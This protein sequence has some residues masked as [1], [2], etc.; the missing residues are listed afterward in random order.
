ML[1]E[2]NPLSI[3]EN[4]YSLLIA[5]LDQFTRK[6]YINEILRGAIY[7]TALFLSTLLLASVLEYF[8][9]FGTTIR[10]FGFYSFLLLNVAGLLFWVLLPVSRL[11]RIGKVI[12]HKQAAHMIGE[13]FSD[14]KDKLLNTLELQESS[15]GSKDLI[16]ASIEQKMAELKPIPF[17]LAINF[18]GNKKY[19]KYALIPLLVVL[20][21]LIQVPDVILQ[22]SARIISYNEEFLPV[23]PFSFLL[24]NENLQILNHDD[25]EIK[26]KMEGRELPATV[27]VNIDGN[28]YRMVRN[29]PNEFS[30]LIRNVDKSKSFN[31]QA[32]GFSSE[33]YDLEVLPRPF[34]KSFQVAL[35]YPKYIGK[36]DEVL[37]NIGDFT[38]PEGTLVK[39]KFAAENAEDLLFNWN[40]V[41]EKGERIDRN[42]FRYSKQV[43]SAG[44]YY[45]QSI[46]EHVPVNDSIGYGVQ[47]IK[48]AHPTI[49]VTMEADTTSLKS[50]FFSGE[51]SDDYGLSALNFS[52][53]Y[54]QSE[55]KNKM[56]GDYKK[57][58]IGV[59]A[60]SIQSFFHHWDLREIGYEAGDEL[61]FFFEVWDN[62][63]VNGRKSS[64]SRKLSIK[65]PNKNEIEDMVAETSTDIKDDLKETLKEAAEVQK[66]LEDVQNRLMNKQRMSWEDKQ[67]VSKLVEKQESLSE[68]IESINK[69]YD[70]M[71]KQ[72]DEFS[73]IDENIREKHQELQKLFD[74]LMD[75]ETK[76]MF[77]EL[78]KLMEENSDNI[79]EN[80]DDIELNNEELEKELDA[81]LEHFKQLELEQK[82]EETI[83]KLEEL[84]EEQK[85]LA[86]ETKNGD[87]SQEELDQKQEELNKEFEELQKDLDQIEEM[88]ED[89]EQPNDM[90]DTQDQEEEISENMKESSEDIKKG[91]N[92]KAA[93]KQQDAA[94]KMEEMKEQMQ[95]QMKSMEME[96][97]ELDYDALRQIMENLIHLSFEQE[98]LIEDLNKIQ[99]YN[100]K[101]INMAREQRKL[102][103]D[104]KMIEDSLTELSKRVMMISGFINKEVGQMNYHLEQT[105][106][107]MGERQIQDARTHQQY[108][109]THVNNL[110]VMLSEVMDQMQQQMS[111]QMSGKQNCQNPNKKGGKKP[112]EGNKKK[113][114]NMRQMQEQLGKQLGEMKKKMEG[115][116]RPLSKDLAKAAAQQ[117][118]LRRELQKFQEMKEGQ[119]GEPANELKEIQ[120]MMD[121]MERDIVNQQITTET[122]M[123]QQEIINKLLESE[124]AE[125]EEEWDNQR[126]STTADQILSP[127][128]KAFEEYKRERLKEIELLNSVPPQ[129]NNYYKQKVQEY[130]EE[131]N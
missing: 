22:S 88:N 85:E 50:Y 21:L 18:A 54:T 72:Q 89:L 30:Y 71:L 114:G 131:I 111:Q 39:W 11:L 103:D 116:Q 100:P 65:A 36:E 110:A 24:E 29:S 120:E 42:S 101:Y 118:A 47:V 48:D 126:E 86:E 124:K 6:Y 23:A 25:F 98:R 60:K 7:F 123:R 67:A 128:E 49:K 56:Q 61:E 26:L 59:S 81:A 94:E 130:F 75:E 12:S 119:G 10:L 68:R 45:V 115:G 51:I 127:S 62:D 38:L 83:D 15:L 41:K 95:A 97:M 28:D 46:N 9:N 69:K 27:R 87:K 77:E 109:M 52:Y 53:R 105:M 113:L 129:L 4:N 58:A 70:E 66:Q 3:L 32:A 16:M 17:S 73:K 55:D 79:D 121:E 122:L 96:S 74:Q 37:E 106:E 33:S 5:K 44:Q 92:K 63:G 102:V 82:M 64:K 2:H 99:S 31:F 104:A 1:E 43:M 108:V 76:K 35:E 117:E 20:L 57:I 19:L 80:L 78:Q 90:E 13:H 107:H 34:L 93:E 112:G 40:G 125:R 14:V 84:A 91:K 8:G